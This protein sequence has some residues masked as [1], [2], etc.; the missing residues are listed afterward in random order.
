LFR[1]FMNFRSNTTANNSLDSESATLA[2]VA[3]GANEYSPSGSPSATVQLVIGEIQKWNSKPLRRSSLWQSKPADCPPGSPE[4]INAVIALEVGPEETPLDLL[5]RL[6]HLERQFG[7]KPQKYPNA[8]RCID[9]DLICFGR[10]KCTH[11]RLTLPHP[12]AHLRGFVMFPLE[13][14][15][16]DMIFPEQNQTVAE[17]AKE[18]RD[19]PQAVWKL[20][21]HTE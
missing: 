6:Q 16:P 1:Q 21:T 15:A 3:L 8:P 10:L 14:I 5:D 9:L 19:T 7:R 12:R 18:L 11:S 17:I 13:E 4:F 20:E 2:I